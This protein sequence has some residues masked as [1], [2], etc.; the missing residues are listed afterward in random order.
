VNNPI[1]VL[2]ACECSGHVRDALRDRGIFATSCDLK[3]S[4]APGPHLQQDI[5]TVD[6][7]RFTHC[8]AF[9]DCT[10]LCSSGLHWNRRRPERGHQTERAL[11]F[12]WTLWASFKGPMAVE[13]PIGCL[14]T[15][16]QKPTQIIQPWQFGHPESKATC[17]WL[18]GFPA[19]QPTNVL[20]LPASG[21]WENQTA[22]GQNRL[23]PSATRAA[24]RARTYQGI[25]DAMAVQWF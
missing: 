24:D 12:V 9:P 10:Y 3:P 5:L 13:N 4:E 17:L 22:S 1:H 23:A 15:R 20:P 7:S 2:V 25:A 11:R 14:S 19:L 21:R 8:I 6:F 16:W 18:R